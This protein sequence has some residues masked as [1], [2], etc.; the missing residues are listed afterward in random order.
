M[1]V[2]YN[3]IGRIVKKRFARLLALLIAAILAV[4]LAP[5]PASA[6]SSYDDYD[7]TLEDV[8]LDHYQCANNP[9]NVSTFWSNPFY[10]FTDPMTDPYVELK[11]LLSLGKGYAVV[12][13]NNSRMEVIYSSSPNAYLRFSTSG[14]LRQIELTSTNPADIFSVAIL[15]LWDDC[16]LNTGSMYSADF[17]GYSHSIASDGVGGYD[18]NKILLSTFDVEYPLGYEGE[19][20]PST[21]TPNPSKYVAMG[22][23]FSSGE[24]AFSYDASSGACHRSMHA[25]PYYVARKKSLG[26]PLFVACSGAMTDDLYNTNPLNTSEAAQMDALTVDTEI[27]T[28]TIGGNDIGFESV[29]KECVTRPLKNGDDCRL[30]SVATITEARIDKLSGIGAATAPGGRTIHSIATIL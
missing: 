27:V 12:Q 4:T 23:S 30:G 17:N 11:S 8:L 29:M 22:D 2:H 19:L 5:L 3:Q 7:F 28:L 26:A 16:T 20:I 10:A 21:Y 14:G 18:Y 25:Y 24:G 15:D 9:V 6:T 13:S 1:Y